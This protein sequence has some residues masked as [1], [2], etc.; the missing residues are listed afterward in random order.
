MRKNKYLWQSIHIRS[1]QVSMTKH[2]YA[3]QTSTRLCQNI[4]M[5]SKQVSMTQHTY[6]QQVMINYKVF[7]CVANKYL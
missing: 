6:A 4:H 3:K 2:Q 5:R 1:K 7:I